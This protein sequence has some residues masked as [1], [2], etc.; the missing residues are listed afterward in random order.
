MN[1]KK[2]IIIL[3]AVGVVC[4]A[5]AFF[6]SKMLNKAPAEPAAKDEASTQ[7]ADPVAAAPPPVGPGHA[8]SVLPALGPKESQLDELLRGVRAREEA[9]M[10]R[11]QALD[12]EAKRIEIARDLLKKQADETLALQAQLVAPLAG[13]K[14]AQR[15]L[16]DSVLTIGKL[17]AGNL[18]KLASTFE[19]MD[20]TAG[21]QKL[22]AMCDNQ[23]D[24][25]A[26]R[27]LHFMSDRA[28]AK[29]LAEIGDKALAAK[30]IDKM[31]RIKEEG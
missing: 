26:A 11:E 20:P 6:A 15:E 29:L 2:L 9:V 17:E 12:H 27:L 18:K 4:F 16:Q 1:K 23:Q 22:L 14:K 30:L 21:S 25:D 19:K 5:G 10:K 8:D 7:P 13:L 28:A 3:S 24:N 31:K